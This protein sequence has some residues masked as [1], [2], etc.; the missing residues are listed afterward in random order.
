MRVKQFGVGLK[1]SPGGGI[2]DGEKVGGWRWVVGSGCLGV[3]GLASTIS[4]SWRLRSGGVR[5]GA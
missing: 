5:S 3:V 2:C 1:W 4:G